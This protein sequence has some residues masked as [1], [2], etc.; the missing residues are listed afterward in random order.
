[1]SEKINNHTEH[2]KLLQVRSQ[3]GKSDDIKELVDYLI[4]CKNSEHSEL[5]L[6]KGI[7][8][9]NGIGGS[10]DPSQM[11]LIEEFFYSALEMKQL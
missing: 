11:Y 7:A 8:Y 4:R 1:M 2:L 6:Q 9:V 10:I 5:I 3:S